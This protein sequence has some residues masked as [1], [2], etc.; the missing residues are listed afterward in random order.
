MIMK[1]F[2]R[3]I[4]IALFGAMIVSCS[5]NTEDNAKSTN[6]ST[7]KQKIPNA[8]SRESV[9]K[10]VRY[11]DSLARTS[12]SSVPDKNLAQ[13]L[14]GAYS[15]FV[16]FFPQDSLSPSFA[17]LSVS[18]AV[19]TYADQQALILID[20]C[21]K[22]YPSHPNK[23]DL[24]MMK[25]L[26]YDDRMHDKDRAAQVYEQIIREFPGTPAADQAKAAMKLSG[27]SDLEMIREM[28]KKNGLR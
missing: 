3:G 6:D 25:A 13:Q 22:N 20:N 26:V 5:T 8:N 2:F 1:L 11:F 16:T 7:A 15:E 23:I 21:L 9:L 19:N 17:F 4:V 28:E 10:K 27:K 12:T 24:L 18:V 14:I